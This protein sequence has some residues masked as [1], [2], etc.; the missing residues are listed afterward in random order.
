MSIKTYKP[1]SA[2]RRAATGHGFA[3]IT[4]NKPHKSLVVGKPERAGRSKTGRMTV[5]YKGGGHKQ[6]YRI[7]D[8][9]RDKFNVPGTV[10]TI[11]YD[12]NR[13]ARIALVSYHDGEKR[14]ILAPVGLK[15]GQVIESGEKAEIKEGNH[16]PISRIPLGVQIH[17]IELKPG[18]GGQVVRSA[19]TGAQL[20]AKEGKFAQIRM[21]SGETR[22]VF[23]NC[24]ATIGQVGNTEHELVSIGKAGR[25]RWRG[26]R[27][28]VRGVAM[29][30][31][32]HPLGGGEGKS[33]GGR[34]P[35]SPWGVPTKGFRTR[36]NKR[37]DGMIVK[38]RKK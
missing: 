31:V 9:K 16:M 32:D 29:N 6:K 27:P 30:P 3:E 23:L 36:N 25:N 18:K 13:S 8:F 19:G 14:Y 26:I 21:P 28:H 34:H 38:R 5:R 7:V 2:G 37:T 33:S 24:Y 17:N 4:T 11:E 10:R 1:T 15:I 12:P 22:L 20:M 35:V